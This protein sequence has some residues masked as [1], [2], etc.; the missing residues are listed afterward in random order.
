MRPTRVPS[1]E[2]ALGQIGPIWAL[3]KPKLNSPPWQGLPQGQTVL[4]LP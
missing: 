4:G 3:A 1:P 2:A